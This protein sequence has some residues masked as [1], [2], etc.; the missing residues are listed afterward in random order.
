MKN[1]TMESL[2]ER[3]VGHNNMDWG[4]MDKMALVSLLTDPTTKALFVG[5]PDSP[6]CRA[7][8]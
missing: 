4:L 5:D 2:S 7:F 3:T 6:E 1:V 8:L